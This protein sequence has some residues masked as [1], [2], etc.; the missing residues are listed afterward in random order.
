LHE[1][2]RSRTS[3][4]PSI[5]SPTEVRPPSPLLSLPNSFFTFTAWNGCKNKIIQTLCVFQ[6][7]PT[8]EAIKAYRETLGGPFGKIEQKVQDHMLALQRR[9]NRY[10]YR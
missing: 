4:T 7:F 9:M 8:L 3:S 5:P 1:V 10:G 6:K 2:V